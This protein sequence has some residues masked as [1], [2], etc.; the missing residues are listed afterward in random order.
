MASSFSINENNNYFGNVSFGLNNIPSSQTNRYI[1]SNNALRNSEG[2]FIR[3][4]VETPETHKN[5]PAVRAFESIRKSG[6]NQLNSD[7]RELESVA[8][9]HFQT[10]SANNSLESLRSIDA[11]EK[12]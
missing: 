9:N 5:K 2:N 7:S 12:K 11:V 8:P 6:H 4:N 1:D 10:F 3:N